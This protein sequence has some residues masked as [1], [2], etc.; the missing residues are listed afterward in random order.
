M[1]MSTE[2]SALLV[3]GRLVLSHLDLPVWTNRIT[4]MRLPN[5][6]GKLSLKHQKRQ[7]V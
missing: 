3:R 6:L 4:E 5:H 2:G 7:H 1:Y